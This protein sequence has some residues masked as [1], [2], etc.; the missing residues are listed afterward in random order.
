MRTNQIL[1]GTYLVVP[2]SEVQSGITKITK[3]Y[4]SNGFLWNAIENHIRKYC[5]MNTLGQAKR[6]VRNLD[7]TIKTIFK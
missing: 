1:N 6:R 4:D 7:L 2:D 5:A 3:A